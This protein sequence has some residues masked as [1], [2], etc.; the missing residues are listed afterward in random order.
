M[1]TIAALTLAAAL[2]S[3]LIRP[4]GETGQDLKAQPATA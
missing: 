3:F 1:A 2:I 4:D